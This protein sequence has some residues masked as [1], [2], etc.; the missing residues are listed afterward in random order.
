MLELAVS[1]LGSVKKASALAN[2]IT[3][4]DLVATLLGERAA[5]GTTMRNP[6]RDV[7]FEGVRC[8]SV[9]TDPPGAAHEAKESKDAAKVRRQA[10]KKLFEKL[11]FE[12]VEEKTAAARAQGS[13][14]QAA[15]E[16]GKEVAGGADLA[17]MIRR[18][19]LVLDTT[20]CDPSPTRPSESPTPQT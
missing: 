5:P 11:E 6:I 13:S 7:R 1:G 9:E 4:G 2:K 18:V 8:M 17:E 12:A 19:G 10:T 16:A 20:Q 3:N 14:I 15:E